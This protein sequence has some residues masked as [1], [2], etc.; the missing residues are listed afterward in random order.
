MSL[1][2]LSR[3]DM[4]GC[5]M[6]KSKFMR[7]IR[8]DLTER[9][10]SMEERRAQLRAE[11]RDLDAQAELL[12]NL[13]QVETR[14]FS[15]DEERHHYLM[16]AG[17]RRLPPIGDFIDDLLR[18]SPMTKDEIRVKAEEAGYF[19]GDEAAGRVLH[20]TLLNLERHGRI[21]SSPDGKYELV[22]GRSIE[23]RLLK[24]IMRK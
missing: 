15:S 24:D 14:R 3:H 7:D 5:S 23:T 19:K 20:A 11:L 2:F 13:I 9:L 18:A 22:P 1:K 8:P 4:R 12:K 17:F 6:R 10:S 21:V 16:S